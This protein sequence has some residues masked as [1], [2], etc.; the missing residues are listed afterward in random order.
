MI[1]QDQRQYLR[2]YSLDRKPA[3]I[4]SGRDVD[5]ASLIAHDSPRRFK[6]LTEGRLSLLLRLSVH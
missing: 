3:Q 5:A 4:E 2:D 6:F 1:A